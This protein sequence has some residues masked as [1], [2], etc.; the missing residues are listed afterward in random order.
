MHK[1]VAK[2]DCNRRSEMVDCDQTLRNESSFSIKWPTRFLYALKET[3]QIL[4]VSKS[5]ER[6][7]SQNMAYASIIYSIVSE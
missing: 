4:I 6:G 1:F 7:A 3:K 5:G 2:N